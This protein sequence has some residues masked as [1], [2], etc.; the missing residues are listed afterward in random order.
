MKWALVSRVCKMTDRSKSTMQPWLPEKFIL[1]NQKPDVPLP[2]DDS[3]QM[4]VN[5]YIY[6]EHYTLWQSLSHIC[7][8][9]SRWVFSK[10]DRIWLLWFSFLLGIKLTSGCVILNRIVH[11]FGCTGSHV[12]PERSYS[13]T[14]F[15]FCIYW[16]SHLKPTQY[17]G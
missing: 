12:F 8:V 9:T 14:W 10:F 6:L 17:S 2:P 1:A 11:V 4:L 15:L 5:N 16:I 3:H 13:I 7:L